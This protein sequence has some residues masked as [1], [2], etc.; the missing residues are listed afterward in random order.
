MRGS[1]YL[2]FIAVRVSLLF[3]LFILLKSRVVLKLIK[4]DRIDQ[5]PLREDERLRIHGDV[6]VHEVV[7]TLGN[8]DAMALHAIHNPLSNT[9]PTEVPEAVSLQTQFPDA[10]Q[11]QVTQVLLPGGLEGKLGQL[12]RR[13]SGAQLIELLVSLGVLPQSRQS[14]RLDEQ[15]LCISHFDPVLITLDIYEI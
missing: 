4:R 10:L 11:L 13:T 5:I 12:Y 1:I 14:L 9:P 6:L 8:L 3:P 2:T 7:V 15:Y